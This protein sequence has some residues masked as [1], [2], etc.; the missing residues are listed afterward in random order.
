MHLRRQVK[1]IMDMNNEMCP[2]KTNWWVHLNGTLKFY[3]SR[4]RKIVEHTNAHGHFELSST[5]WWTIMLVV[6]STIK[7][8]NKIVFQ[9]HN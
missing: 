1:L 3:I 4:Q 9:L 5:K 6:V 2:K 7:E 8:I